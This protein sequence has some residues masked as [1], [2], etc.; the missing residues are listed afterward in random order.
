MNTTCINIDEVVDDWYGL[1][2]TSIFSVPQDIVENKE[3]NKFKVPSGFSI[4]YFLNM[5]FK[6]SRGD[7]IK[8]IEKMK[9]YN[10][11]QLIKYFFP[12]FFIIVTFLFV[13]N[14]QPIWKIW[15]SE[16]VSNIPMNFK[17]TYI[18]LFLVVVGL[19][20]YSSYKTIFCYKE[21][22]DTIKREKFKNIYIIT[23]LI[24]V[25]MII[26][27][28]FI[29]PCITDP[30]LN[31][32]YKEESI[33]KD[34]MKKALPLGILALLGGIL[35]IVSCVYYMKK[36]VGN[37]NFVRMDSEYFSV[38]SK[39]SFFIYLIFSLLLFTAIITNIFR[40]IGSFAI[41]VC[42]C[43][44]YLMYSLIIY[45]FAYA[46]I[47]GGDYNKILLF[48]LF[49]LIFSVLIG[50][51]FLSQL[52]STMEEIC[53]KAPQATMGTGQ[54]IMNMIIPMILTV[55]FIYL[56]GNIYSPKTFVGSMKKKFYLYYTIYLIIIIYSWFSYSLPLV[57][58]FSTLQW[59]FVTYI[60][61]PWVKIYLGDVKALTKKVISKIKGKK[62][63]GDN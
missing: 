34:F 9:L 37:D 13:T 44:L 16:V 52:V 40:H 55:L 46:V 18:V 48:T 21:I 33:K 49:L 39:I 56:Y 54:V 62:Q 26:L 25:G 50:F 32:I 27:N 60:Q 7:K 42:L 10:I 19:V 63:I 31:T 41:K 35:I 53:D 57:G 45:L 58:F 8:A 51:Y 36:R 12:V 38:C 3:K 24:A 4:A 11:Y 2:N 6:I 22:I 5:F 43:G 20:I 15:H 47:Q 14:Y 17:I 23:L 59:L 30:I 1:S 61:W 29:I 28:V